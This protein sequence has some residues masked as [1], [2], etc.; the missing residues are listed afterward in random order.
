MLS[1]VGSFKD[2][3][4]LLA[5]EAAGWVAATD[6]TEVWIEVSGNEAT[7]MFTFSVSL[8]AVDIVAVVADNEVELKEVKASEMGALSLVLAVGRRKHI[9]GK[10]SQFQG[11]ASIKTVNSWLLKQ[12]QNIKVGKLDSGVSTGEQSPSE[13]VLAPSVPLLF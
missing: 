11:M 2:E 5:I 3:G 13:A 7:A 10:R 12:Q 1:D 6:E 8:L 9:E 4:R